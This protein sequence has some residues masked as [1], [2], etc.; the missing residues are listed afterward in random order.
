M[1]KLMLLSKTPTGEA[2]TIASY[3]LKGDVNSW[4]RT[5][6]AFNL[7]F[8]FSWDAFKLCLENKYFGYELLSPKAKEFAALTMGDVTLQAYFDKF[9]DLSKFGPKNANDE[10]S[11]A[12]K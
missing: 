3:Y 5:V 2:V 4:W 11:L 9:H 8:T 1:E 10:D 12:N 7:N 6:L